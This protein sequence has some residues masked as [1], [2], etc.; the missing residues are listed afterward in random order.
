M[1]TEI[2]YKCIFKMLKLNKGQIYM[3]YYMKHTVLKLT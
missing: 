3:V 1:Y 2:S